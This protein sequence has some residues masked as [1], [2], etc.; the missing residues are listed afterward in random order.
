MRLAF[1]ALASIFGS[2]A[3]A[4]LAVTFL[5]GAPKDRFVFENTG[6]CPLGP[7]DLVVDL[8][9]S[10]AGLIFDVTATGAGVQVYQP[11]EL[12]AGADS[13]SGL[14]QVS[15]GDTGLVL[16]VSALPPGAR[17]AFTIDVDDTINQ[18]EITVSNA[19]IAGAEVRLV[20]D[21]T[22]YVG[23]FTDAARA[24]VKLPPCPTT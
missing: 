7:T 24:V 9:G 6:N 21:G 19:E 5:E 12:V 23:T 3:S 11:F 1:A 13:L 18:R 15:D 22:A 17:I 2:V 4:D 20:H 16:P 10:V 8:S 14:P